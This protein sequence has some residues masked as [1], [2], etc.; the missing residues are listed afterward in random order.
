MF[1]SKARTLSSLRGKLQTATVLPSAIFSVKD[2]AETPERVVQTIQENEELTDIVIVRSSARREDVS[3]GSLAG[4]YVSKRC[5]RLAPS[6]SRAIGEVVA[7]Y[8]ELRYE[9]EIFV[10]PFLQET[11]ISGVAFNWDVKS[12]VERDIVNY[13]RENDTSLVTSGREGRLD[14]YVSH[15]YADTLHPPPLG[16]VIALLRELEERVGRIP[17]DVEFAVTADSGLILLQLRPLAIAVQPPKFAE[18]YQGTLQDLHF[19]LL[20]ILGR[21]RDVLG[22][23]GL[24]SLM[25]DWNPAEMIGA[26]PRPLAFSIYR[27]LITDSICGQRRRKYGY[28]DT[29]GVPLIISLHGLPY[30][31]VRASFNSFVPASLDEDI[32]ER[33]VN[34]AIQRL[35]DNPFLH[36]KVE[37][38]VLPSC[39]SFD[40]PDKLNYL[41]ELSSNDRQIICQALLD[42]T[43]SFLAG[44]AARRFR[45]DEKLILRLQKRQS[46]QLRAK[47]T[48]L[49]AHLYRCLFECRRYGTS[50]FVGIARSAFVATALVRSMV[51]VGALSQ[52]ELQGFLGSLNTPVSRIFYDRRRWSQE[53]FL[54]EYGHLRP[55]TYDIRVPSYAQEPAQYLASDA[56]TQVVDRVARYN[57]DRSTL[58]A[59]DRLLRI[60]QL[61]CSASQ[62]FDFISN[63]IV[64]RET[65]KFIFS[66]SLSRSLDL[67]ALI[68]ESRGVSKE[69]MS[70]A[71]IRDILELRVSTWSA[72]EVIR[73]SVESGKRRYAQTQWISLPPLIQDPDEV[74]A[75]HDPIVKPNFV[76]NKIVEG[77]VSKPFDRELRGAVV[78]IENADPGFDWVFG[79]RIAG[80]ITAYGGVNSHMAIR[81]AEL[82]LPA[83]IGV[84][85]RHFETWL[86]AKRLR[87]DCGV[88]TVLVLE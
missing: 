49:I 53:K 44:D 24:L 87:I 21:S 69:E 9:D 62:V 71:D 51:G 5:R 45:L 26:K 28:R 88:E 65:A 3:G 56:D 36:D 64:S 7:S 72:D 14:L 22:N 80:L 82:N 74:W 67:L 31:D 54:E 75:F 73:R 2:W 83:V 35:V 37:F 8:E 19:S 30:V 13:T 16:S 66:R 76:T 52:S 20:T 43:K 4:R 33:L 18:D 39:Y 17:L 10:Q 23:R 34:S 15:R 32:A 42:V 70:F 84:G 11:L 48:D 61:P 29:R 63:A 60:H 12:G 79:R 77:H 1:A 58:S 25:S 6:L 50:A 38:E 78:L 46:E 86:R 57:F 68:G 27:H 59:V 47:E 81:A 40:T 41:L 55:G 85:E